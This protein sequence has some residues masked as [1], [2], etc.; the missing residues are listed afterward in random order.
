M[1]RERVRIR[2]VRTV[3]ATIFMMMI[4]Q[5]KDSANLL[6][7][8]EKRK[9]LT[10]KCFC[11]CFFVFRFKRPISITDMIVTDNNVTEDITDKSKT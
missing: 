1:D 3:R 4:S 2:E 8:R 10:R 9:F 11:F 6:F 5:I 7:N